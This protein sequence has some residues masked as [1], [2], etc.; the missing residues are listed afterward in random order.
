M[1]NLAELLNEEMRRRG[2]SMREVGNLTGVTHTTINRILNGHR[3]NLTTLERVSQFLH[4]Q[5]A[6]FIPGSTGEDNL[7]RALAA[8]VRK[9]PALEGIL[10]RAADKVSDGEIAPEVLRDIVRYATWRIDNSVSPQ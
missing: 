5:A 4:V 9:D 1:N 2:L 7:I 6:D 10:L 8:I 3:V